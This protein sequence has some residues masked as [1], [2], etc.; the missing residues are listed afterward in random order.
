MHTA[1]AKIGGMASFT[2][3]DLAAI[4]AA[5]ASGELTVRAADGKLITL[6]SVSELMQARAAIV[7]EIASTGTPIAARRFGPR[8]LLADFRE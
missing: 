6:R 2:T 7:A 1:S 3:N 5:I 8:T 4:N